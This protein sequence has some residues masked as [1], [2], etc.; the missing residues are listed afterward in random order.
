MF[1][2]VLLHMVQPGS[3]VQFYLHLAAHPEIFVRM[4]QDA[5][6]P[7]FFHVSYRQARKFLHC[8]L[9]GVLGSAYRCRRF[10]DHAAHNLSRQG[11]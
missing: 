3:P 10:L 2:G 6:V 11:S 8:R 9:H 1:P 5:S 7:G 4:V